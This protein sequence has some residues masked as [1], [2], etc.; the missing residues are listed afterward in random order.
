MYAVVFCVGWYVGLGGN[1]QYDSSIQG[2][3]VMGDSMKPTLSDKQYIFISENRNELLDH[4]KVIVFSVSGATYVKRI[5]GL[6]GEVVELREGYV[7]VNGEKLSETYLLEEGKTFCRAS[8]CPPVTV[9]NGYVYV[10]GDNREQSDD[11]RVLGFI[12]VDTIE[13]VVI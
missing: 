13:G 2:Y 11:S 6:P 3:R 12:S 4:G 7:Y 10:L 1:K 9:P 5:I 8:A